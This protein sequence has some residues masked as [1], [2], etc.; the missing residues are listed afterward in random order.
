MH[1]SSYAAEREALKIEEEK[2]G[3][4]EESYADV[5]MDAFPENW[6]ELSKLKISRLKMHS[7]FEQF[8]LSFL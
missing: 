2:K 4:K 5:E 3:R 8:L 6:E 7:A 1:N